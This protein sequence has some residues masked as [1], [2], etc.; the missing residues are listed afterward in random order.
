ML[1]LQQHQEGVTRRLF[2]IGIPRYLINPFYGLI[3]KW[4]S[5]SGNEWT[6]KRLK[7]LKV[8]LIRQQSG[9]PNLTWVRKNR[10]GEIAGIIGSLFRWAQQS[11]KNFAK[12][13]Q[14]LMA[15]S[16][17]IFPTLTESQKEKFLSGVNPE[18]TEDGLTKRF[19]EEFSKKI[20]QKLKRV[21]ILK[22]VEPLVTYQGSPGKKSPRLF[23]K[24]SVRQCDSVLDDLQFFNTSGGLNT[25][26]KFRSLYRPLL[27]GVKERRDYLDNVVSNVG[28]RDLPK[29]QVIGGEIHFLQEPGGK[30]RSV[31]SPLRIHQEALRPLG[32]ALYRCIK[33]LPW[34]CTH[35]QMRAIPHIQSCL[36][37]GG[38]VHS[39][40][41]SSAT[42]R[43]PL[44]LQETAL[45]AI[46]HKRFW[47]HIDLF[48]EISRSSWKSPI[49]EIQW[50]K[51]QPLGLYPSF[52]AFS[53]THGLLLLHL[54][55]Y[56]FH[57]QFFV[58]GD[59]VVILE[60]SLKDKYIS[61]LDRMDCPWSEDKSISSSQLSEFA[62][63]IVTKERVIPQLKWRR[64]SDD[65][66]LDIC[67][68]L[69]RQSRCLLSGRQKAVFDKVAN[70]CD[71]I[72]LN[73]SLPGD[74]LAKMVERTVDFYQ[75]EKV[76]LGTLMGLR[77]KFNQLVYT[78]SEKLDSDELS[79]LSST[80]DEKVKS[81]LYQTLF[82]RWSTSNSIG[83]EGLDTL[84]Q[85]LDLQPRLPLRERQPTR[86]T[87]LERY[88]RL[89]TK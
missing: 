73:F 40:D 7:S 55:N 72:G 74:N 21:S 16:F 89:I 22:R 51:G 12:A 52:A 85:A 15:Y 31:A 10:R 19:H 8:D 53:L 69:G 26:I 25:Y 29:S 65:N 67:R 30:L 76:V 60:P 54:A 17:Y 34:D 42:D 88:E 4:E 43:F 35:D 20:R 79:E 81:A 23:G 84:P 32:E 49:G 41:L 66:F 37:Q 80:F 62:G 63:K 47:K 14:A 58:V 6:L 59:D 86:V 39:V 61:M 78:S 46:F 75:P 56:D 2:V 18:I 3:C 5:C 27:E 71:P 70:L 77:R 38:K 36:R 68:L 57:N 48:I 44:T 82:S 13:I 1:Q 28:K 87:Q 64:M 45:R 33:S 50:T 83:L 9:L 11:E 24:R